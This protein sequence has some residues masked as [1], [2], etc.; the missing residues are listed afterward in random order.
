M[1]SASG[2][3]WAGNAGSTP[4]DFLF[5][6]G[7][8]RSVGI[9]GAY[10]ALAND[11]NALLYNPAGL[12]MENRHE[13]TF[14]H[15][16]YVQGVSQ[17]YGAVALTQGWGL[18]FNYARFADTPRTTYAQPNGSLDNFGI[19]DL[20]VTVGYGRTLLPNL[21]LGAGLKYL[22][23]SIDNQSAS[24]VAIDLGAMYAVPQLPN[25]RLGLAVQNVG[26]DLR[27]RGDAFNG[28]RE[29]LP[30][31]VRGGASYGFSYYGLDHTLA[32][33][34][35]KARNSD[36]VVGIGIESVIMKMFALRFGFNSRNSSDIGLSGGVGWK[37]ETFNVD[38][39]IVPYGALG[40][41]NRFSVSMRFGPARGK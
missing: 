29:S 4:F 2:A 25:L 21:S 19:N 32:L 16:S 28:P 10:T 34:L 30:L 31:N 11:A 7:G 9:G 26:P 41:S 14:M 35:S 8:A 40:L 37:N 39:A 22:R 5:L 15:N 12:G 33:D 3:A 17:D 23:E 1:L 20:A 36:T 13:A 24:G 18:N 6:D 38:Y 27:Y